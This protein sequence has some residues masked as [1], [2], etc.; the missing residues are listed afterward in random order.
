MASKGF[1][2]VVSRVASLKVG[3]QADN[4]ENNALFGDIRFKP[5]FFKALR[6]FKHFFRG[7]A[8]LGLLAAT[9]DAS[10]SSEIPHPSRHTFPLQSRAATTIINNHNHFLEVASLH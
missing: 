8:V 1:L 5:F 10:T 6:E 3:G 9:I 2:I 4:F 7:I